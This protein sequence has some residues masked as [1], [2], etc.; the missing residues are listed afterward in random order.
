MSRWDRKRS[1]SNK[2]GEDD[3]VLGRKRSYS[4]VRS[5]KKGIDDAVLLMTSKVFARLVN[6]VHVTVISKDN[7]SDYGYGNR[8]N[9]EDIKNWIRNTSKSTLTRQLTNEAKEDG[10]KYQTQEASH[11]Q[12]NRRGKFDIVKENSYGKIIEPLETS[13]IFRTDC[14]KLLTLEKIEN[15][16]LMTTIIKFV[17]VVEGLSTKIL[18]ILNQDILYLIDVEN[19]FFRQNYRD[20]LPY[21]LDLLNLYFEKRWRNQ[22]M[23]GERDYRDNQMMSSNRIVFLPKDSPKAWGRRILVVF[24]VF[25]SRYRPFI[26]ALDHVKRKMEREEYVFLFDIQ[27]VQYNI[28][29]F[30]SAEVQAG[31]DDHSPESASKNYSKKRRRKLQELFCNLRF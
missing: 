12:H 15:M 18:K 27:C 26:A 29:F 24:P 7:F 17:E 2:Q 11:T 1:I 16:N 19:I 3:A 8:L 21:V 31:E 6:H 5:Y 30:N 9:F 10:K 28:D 13:N 14:L 20:F 25:E 23:W 4:D 22:I